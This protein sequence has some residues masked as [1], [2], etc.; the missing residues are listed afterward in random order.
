MLYY[1]QQPITDIVQMLGDK[2][3]NNLKESMIFEEMVSNPHAGRDMPTT[4]SR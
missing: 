2:C 1:T 4:P 3:W